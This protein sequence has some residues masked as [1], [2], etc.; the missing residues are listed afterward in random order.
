[1][2]DVKLTKEQF[3]EG[4]VKRGWTWVEGKSDAE[5]DGIVVKLK[6]GHKY[7]VPMATLYEGVYAVLGGRDIYHMSRVVGY[8][9]KIQNWN[10]SK[11]G[12]LA[13]RQKGNFRIK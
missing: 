3:T 7:Y 6:N 4:V 12:E 2:K 11:L 8:Y 10:D 13:D 9:S 5:I 1:M